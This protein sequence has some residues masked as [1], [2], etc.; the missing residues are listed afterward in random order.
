MRDQLK[1]ERERDALEKALEGVQEIIT[2]ANKL[3]PD[4]PQPDKH[5]KDKG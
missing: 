5:K 1:D 3:P 4:E 2:A